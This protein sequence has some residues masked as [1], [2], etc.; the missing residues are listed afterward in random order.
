MQFHSPVTQVRALTYA[1]SQR[2]LSRPGKTV[3]I[4]GQDVSPIQVVARAQIPTGVFVLHASKVL[5][6]L[7]EEL[8]QYLLVAKGANVQRGTPL[9]RRPSRLGRTKLFRS[10]VDGVIRQIW[11]GYLVLQQGGAVEEIR[12][13]VEGRVAAVIPSRGVIL[14]TNGTLI[15]ALWD[16][17]KEG[18]GAL[19]M[20]ANAPDY[21][22]EADRIAAGA[23]NAIL[24]TGNVTQ[25]QVL[26]R[27]E[28][29]GARGLITGA[30][31]AELSPEVSYPIAI[32]DGVGGSSM[33]EPIFELLQQSEGRQASILAG[34]QGIGGQRT[35]IIIPLPASNAVGRVQRTH[36]TPEV[37]SLVRV[38]RSGRSPVVGKV[39]RLYP[40]AKRLS[41]NVMMPG[42][43]VM[44]EGGKQFYVPYPNLDLIVH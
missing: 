8:E 4:A 6:V 24:V 12:A 32:T 9:L 16:S 39:T 3:V 33:A 21:E 20:A 42:A 25:P 28:E 41:G 11:H 44:S 26:L 40:E 43:D 22:L 27:L 19:K 38:L 37:G 2:L 30:M 31:P 36:G 15:Q 17:G 29:I 7:P 23:G 18:F 1:R 5:D 14:E 35:E 13:M 10:P 34:R